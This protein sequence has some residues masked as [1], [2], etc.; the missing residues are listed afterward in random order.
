MDFK[1][2]K[3]GTDDAEDFFPEND[4]ASDY[5]SDGG[6]GNGGDGSSETSDSELFEEPAGSSYHEQKLEKNYTVL[7]EAD[8]RQ[9][10]EADTAGL[11][12]VLSISK[13]EAS[14]LLL[15][16]NWSVSRVHEE[17]FGDEFGV[18]KKVG[19]LENPQGQQGA[20]QK[21]VSS[22]H[23]AG[24][25][26]FETCGVCFESYPLDSM[27][28]AACGHA[29]C[30][31]CWK[32][33]IK[34]KVGD[35]PECLM[36]K[37]P[38]PMCF[39]AVGENLIN[40]LASEED[41]E[42]YF[43]FLARSYV[44]KSKK[45]KWCPAPDCNFAIDF[46]AC[47]DE[48]FDVSCACS[49]A[50]CWNCSQ[51]RHRPVDCDIVAKWIL[52]SNSDSEN[53]TWKKAY[54]KPCPKC[55]RAIEKNEGCMHMTCSQPCGF[56]FCWL[57]LGAWRG[58][59][60]GSCNGYGRDPKDGEIQSLRVDILRYQHYYDRWAANERSRQIALEDLRKVQDKHIEEIAC[61]FQ[62]PA[63][64]L[65]FLAEAWQQIVECRR[66]LK[67]TYAY[68]YYLPG[69][70]LAKKQLF[71]YS[72]GQA[73][74]GLERLHGCAEKE[75]KEF[76]EADRPSEK[77]SEFRKNLIGL[78]TVTKNYFDNLVTALENGLSDVTSD[79]GS[80]SKRQ[81]TAK[82]C[83]IKA[84]LFAA[85]QVR[86]AALNVIQVQEPWSCEF[87]TYTNPASA[88]TC[89]VCFRGSWSCGH[90]TYANPRFATTCQL[91]N[92]PR[93]ENIPADEEAPSTRFDV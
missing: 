46:S 78:T 18:R 63:S 67:W 23:A 39:V 21:S 52:K 91:C 48:N 85:R 37:C 69:N 51:E 7:R 14:I 84:A 75:L 81:K 28:S 36:L 22:D 1:G 68:G 9:R 87:C 40:E 27:K 59:L 76:L 83:S 38:Q 44:E 89:Q 19:L 5:Y 2:D 6:G 11:S 41:K 70:N 93:F 33:Y 20:D 13:G 31:E 64:Q 45:R 61:K 24:G 56:Q 92:E 12:A 90:C 82:Y 55:N 71:E 35:G 15:H 42:K 80:S 4:A 58:H 26:V 57:C 47:G 73:E 66:V 8:I 60:A 49:H 32:L 79:V 88:T 74:S 10:M 86:T 43:Y 62:Q 65:T 72:Q 16:Y 29:F 53:E 17:W 34:T 30:F 50:F 77:F 25:I 54:T 3:H